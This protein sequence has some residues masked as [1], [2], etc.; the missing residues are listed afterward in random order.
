MNL[1]DKQI[2]KLEDAFNEEEDKGLCSSLVF[3]ISELQDL[4]AEIHKRI[5]E[6]DKDIKGE[7]SMAVI[8]FLMTRQE[9][10]INLAG[11][12]TPSP[13]RQADYMPPQKIGE[14]VEEIGKKQGRKQGGRVN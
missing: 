6:L 2:K 8:G 4:K 12:P 11:E 9:E 5:G 7:T 1:I 10:L 3:S 14:A 13:R